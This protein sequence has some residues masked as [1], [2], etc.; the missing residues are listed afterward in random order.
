[1]IPA[2][3]AILLGFTPDRINPPEPV[4]YASTAAWSNATTTPTAITG[5]TFTPIA[6]AS[7]VIDIEVSATASVATEGFTLA[8]NPGNAPSASVDL[9]VRGATPTAEVLVI[10][11]AVGVTASA[12]GTSSPT[13][14]GE[15]THAT[16]RAYITAHASAPTAF[17]VLGAAETGGANS[18]AVAVGEA[19]MLV[20][21]VR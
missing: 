9:R 8:V 6:G 12:I 18:V 4:E 3:L 14:V 10:G 7:Y 5:L 16:G 17:T 21:R 1:M 13:V 11:S 15:R 19:T 20:R 2:L